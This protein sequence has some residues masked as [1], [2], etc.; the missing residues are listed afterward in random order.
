MSFLFCSSDGGDR[1]S[2]DVIGIISESWTL[3]EKSQFL[4]FAESSWSSTHRLTSSA[5]FITVSP[6][7]GEENRHEY[8]RWRYYWTTVGPNADQYWEGWARS[9]HHPGE[10]EVVLKFATEYHVSEWGF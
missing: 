4:L 10:G 5:N 6:T 8:L 2:A 7:D 3:T 1:D 9:V